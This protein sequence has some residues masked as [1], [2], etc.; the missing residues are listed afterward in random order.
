MKK[1]ILYFFMLMAASGMA[2]A[3][4]IT[5]E[6]AV[7]SPRVSLDEALQLT[8]TFTGVKDN[9]D[10][11]SLP[12][13]D[14]FSAKYLGPSTSVS[15]VNGDYHSERS[16]I[17]NL[18]PNKVGRFQIPSISATVAGHTYRTKPIDVEVFE[19]AAQAQASGGT[20]GQNQAPSAESLKD[21][22]LVMVSV[23]KF[24]VYLNERIPVTI[25]LLVNDVPLRDIQ[26][27]QFDKTGFVVDDFEKPQQSSGVI[28]GVRYDTVEFKTNIYPDRLGD[29]T[30]GPAQIQGNIIYKTGQ[31][32]PFNQDNNFFGPDVFNN[33]FDSYATRPITVASQPVLL[34]VSPL[35]SERRPNDFSGAIGQSFDFR[36]SVS[37][38]KVKA[39]DPLTLKMDVTGSGNFKNLQMPDFQA[40]GFKSYAP[41]IKNTPDEKTAEQVIIPTSA[42]IKE[43][44]ALHF[45]YFDTSIKDYKTITQGPFPIQVMAPSPDQEFKAVGFSDV[46]H[47]ASTLPANQ[48]SFGKMFNDIYKILR[49]LCGLIWF[50][51]SLGFIF[52]AGV[53]YFLWRRFQDR[54]ENDPAFARRLK[55]LKEARQA[56]VAA[57]GYISTG[58]PKDFYALLSK[59]LRDYLAN[60]WHQSS[61]ALSVEG[62]LSRLKT[63]QLDE[64]RMAQVKTILEQS[65]LVCFA[66]AIR[67]AAQMR[68][69]LSQAQDLIAHLEKF[70]K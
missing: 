57:G 4:A 46:G 61:A 51:V 55:A 32:N 19:S 33:F 11:I 37:P 5:F 23:D 38:L 26:Y 59:V 3:D 36:V 39:G 42:G 29:L 67:D 25:K 41:Q 52:A 24:D 7:N 54:L 27:P 63:A 9:L 17:Y 31:S 10:P 49:K 2:R 70:L 64:S 21:K 40:Q 69:D 56:L 66:G 12:V 6:A 62:I 22:I 65:D 44:P 13:L 35:P 34:H 48:F 20:S 28:N 68:A 16:F 50:W 53:S 1:F 15:I 60:K 43:A 47:E 30:I 45:S 18:F 8:L 58:R 14:G